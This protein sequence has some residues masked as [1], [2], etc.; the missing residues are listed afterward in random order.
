[1]LER[2]CLARALRL[3]PPRFKVDVTVVDTC[4]V[5]AGQ[6]LLRGTLWLPSGRHAQGPFPAVVIR[7]PY[8]AQS[9]HADWGNIVLAERGYAVLLQDTRGRFG[10][11]GT[12]VPVEHEREDGKDTVRWVRAQPWCDGR[13]AVFGPSYLGLT[14]WACVGACE[15][16]EIQA[17][18][19]VITQA[20]VRSAVF[21]KGGAI[22][23]ELLVLWFYLIEVI[24][25]RNPL[26]LGLALYR[27]WRDHRLSKAAMH[28]PLGE[29]DTLLFGRTWDFF[30]RRR[31]RTLLGRWTVLVRTLNAVRAARR[32]PRLC[33][34]A[35][36][37]HG[38]GLA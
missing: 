31:T 5:N 20:V 25:H 13:V 22:A 2:R 1:M 23:L 28:E 4:T 37:P 17:H 14:A 33:G 19:P 36:H 38:H 34:T 10:S 29:L 7:S 27:D 9:K 18:V 26:R 24:T 32:A 11:D 21:S 8:G 30:S 15:P 12:F 16:G 6:N 35:T 3:G